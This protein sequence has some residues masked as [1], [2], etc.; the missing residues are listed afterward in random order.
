MDQFL[1]NYATPIVATIA[2]INGFVALMISH[3]FKDN[4][5]AKIILV[6]VV[7]VLSVG[8][9]V[10]TF[11]SQ[12]M[13]VSAK[14]ADDDRRVA[15]KEGIG[16]FI[17]EGNNLM[18]NAANEAFPPPTDSAQAWADRVEA[19]LNTNLGP[20]YVT[21]FRDGTGTPPIHFSNDAAHQNL[22][23]GIYTRLLRLEEFSREPL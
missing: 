2:V 18:T 12:R 23:V 21:R 15:V 14:A 10:E 8:A 4:P 7:G 19:F 9:I 3:I 22:R 5:T 20:S 11:Y 16:N 1:R 17:A 13:I 6:A